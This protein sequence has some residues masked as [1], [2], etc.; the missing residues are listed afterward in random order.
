MTSAARPTPR[1][2]SRVVSGLLA[3]KPLARFAR[4]QARTLMIQR[5]E[6][7][8]VYWRQEVQA[9]RSRGDDHEWS[10]EWDVDLEQVR[11]PEL[12]YPDY[13]RRSFHAY[14]EGNL[15]WGP[16]M[17]VEVAAKAVHA[18]LWPEGDAAGDARLRQSYH[19]V[20]TA[21]LPTIPN[22]ILDLGCSV[23]M[24]TIALQQVYPQAQLTGVDLSPY[25]LAIAHY[26][27]RHRA[28]QQHHSIRWLHAPAEQTG[29][30]NASFDLV[31]ACL[32][33]HE[34]PCPAAVEILQE[35]RR[36][37]RPGGHLAIMEMNPKS[38]VYA[39]IPPYILTL[40]K[41]TEPYLDDYFSFNLEQAIYEAG[42]ANPTQICNSIRHR[43]LVAQVR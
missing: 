39:Q 31:S 42:F 2:A 18:R 14:D 7:I 32:V 35:A 28:R 15:G 41:S 6:S 33:F 30:P 25:F 19:Q 11:N 37:L 5:A 43:T 26:R 4:H 27:A 40:L 10:S 20:L 36:V 22:D 17:E 1:F 24:S 23:G 16:A 3:I 34:L 29:L 21:Q 8:G 38:E 12:V 13:Y 9:L